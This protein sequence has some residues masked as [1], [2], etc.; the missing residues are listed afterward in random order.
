[1]NDFELY[2]RLGLEHILNVGAID[3][4][5]FLTALI[6]VFKITE[7]RKLFWLVT[8]FTIAHTTSLML[9]VFGVLKIDGELIE[10]LILITILITALSN[11]WI[12]NPKNLHQTHYYFS[13][14][15]GLIHGLGFAKD[16][17]MMLTGQS[18]K[19]YP[20]LSFALGIE[21]AQI[22]L[23][24]IILLFFWLL[25][26]MLKYSKREVILLFSGLIMGY[27]LALLA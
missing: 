7:W 26:N 17:K 18:E 9:S 5:L 6:M 19:I 10:K 15:F 21:L 11:I 4:I 22:L 2:F 1:M 16:F 12:K 27:T 3:H 8:L 23:G 20:L 14:F 13:F 25:I 24:L